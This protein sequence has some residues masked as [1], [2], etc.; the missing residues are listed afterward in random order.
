VA[1]VIVL[2]VG[3]LVYYSGLLTPKP[4]TLT[5]IIYMHDWKWDS[6]AAP[7]FLALDKGWY[8]DAGLD[9]QI[10][11]GSGSSYVVKMLGAG[12]ADIAQIT[13]PGVIVG[14][15]KGILVKS[16]AMI[17]QSEPLTFFSLADSGIKS[18]QDWIGKKIG[19]QIESTNYIIYQGVLQKLGIDR[20]KITEVP[21]GF[22]SVTPLATHQVDVT[23]S[24]EIQ[25]LQF[26]T[27]KIAITYF[28]ASDLGVNMYS[29]SLATT[30][31][32]ASRNPDVVKK[33]VEISLKAWKYTLAN[34]DETVNV[35][36]KYAKELDKTATLAE[37]NVNSAL[38][39]TQETKANGLGYMNSARWEYTRDLLF[40]FKMI[41]TKF[42]ATDLYT[43]QFLP[44]PPVMP[45]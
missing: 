28:K 1:L 41:T 24:F 31:G 44:S 3:G 35:L 38:L 12:Q 9:V 30:D 45:A 21:I 2:A 19:V 7:Y 26:E 39:V 36:L 16:V 8:K 5:K 40:N 22:D 15:D 6:K 11:P 27:K 33:F 34:P 10:V 43:N 17:Y 18:P 14:R 32:F 20:T 23:M 13:A 29:T 42:N 37:M 4:T 25:R